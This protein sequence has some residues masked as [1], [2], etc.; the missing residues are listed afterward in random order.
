MLT[1]ATTIHLLFSIDINSLEI[2]LP[3]KVSVYQVLCAGEVEFG[4]DAKIGTL[5][6]CYS[7]SI[8]S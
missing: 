4:S 2:Q 6:Y 8:F 7:F 5:I 1:M 3:E